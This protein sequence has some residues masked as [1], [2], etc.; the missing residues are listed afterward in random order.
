MLHVLLLSLTTGCDVA[1][2]LQ[3]AEELYGPELEQMRKEA[4]KDD[5]KDG[6]DGEAVKAEEEE[7]KPELEFDIEAEIAAEVKG[8]RKPTSEPL[9]TNVKVD[10]QCG[11]SSFPFSM[12][13]HPCS[14]LPSSLNL[15]R[16]LPLRTLPGLTTTATA[17]ITA[18]CILPLTTFP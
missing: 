5:G 3:Y 1:Y 13:Q 18:S 16:G 6:G 17:T 4:P 11:E 8:L 12:P 15:Q 7:A 10:V 14:P 9:F 2:N